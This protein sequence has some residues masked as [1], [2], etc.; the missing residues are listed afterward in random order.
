MPSSTTPFEPRVLAGPLPSAGPE[1]LIA[2]DLRLGRL[3]SLTDRRN[4]IAVLDAS[5]ILGRGG[6]G[7]PVGRKWRSVAERST[8]PKRWLITSAA[9]NSWLA[10]T[11]FDAR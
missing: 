11:W 2:H 4:L 1:P 9:R 5:G 7:F 6:A 8:S 3:P 10:W